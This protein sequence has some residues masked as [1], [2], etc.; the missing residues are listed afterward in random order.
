MYIAH[1]DMP[2]QGMTKILKLGVI[3]EQQFLDRW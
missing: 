1:I 3:P 2:D